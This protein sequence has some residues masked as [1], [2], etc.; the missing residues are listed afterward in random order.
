[1]QQLFHY[2]HFLC[3]CV[4]LTLHIIHEHLHKAK[5]KTLQFFALFDVATFLWSSAINKICCI[6]RYLK[7]SYFVHTKPYWSMLRTKFIQST[8]SHL[9]FYRFPPIHVKSSF[10]CSDQHFVQFITHMQQN[11]IFIPIIPITTWD[12]YRHISLLFSHSF[13]YI[14]NLLAILFPCQAVWCNP[15]NNSMGC[16]F[17]KPENMIVDLEKK[18]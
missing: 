5:M 18:L 2:V 7:A 13:T 17:L 11:Q 16:E 6:L 8:L 14:I 12:N 1:M 3:C 9:I 15:T 10:R 4:Y